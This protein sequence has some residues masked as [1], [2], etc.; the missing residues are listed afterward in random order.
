MVSQASTLRVQDKANW[1]WL[2]HLQAISIYLKLL[3]KRAAE[4]DPHNF[5]PLPDSFSIISYYGESQTFT[6]RG[7]N[8]KRTRRIRSNRPSR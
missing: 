7:R 5:K 4:K 1:I 3:L 8:A 2:A 6:L